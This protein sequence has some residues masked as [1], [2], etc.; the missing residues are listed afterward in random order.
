M[1]QPELAIWVC[2]ADYEPLFRPMKTV[3]LYARVSTLDQSCAMQLEDLRRYASQRFDRQYEYVDTGV[4]GTQRSRPQLDAL[5]KDAH[6]R[7]FGVVLVWKFDRFAR[8]LKHLIDSLAEFGA[9]GIN[10]ISFTE[11]IDTTTPSGQLLFHIVGAVAQFERDLISERVRAGIAHARAIGKHIGRPRAQV[12][13]EQVKALRG[14]GMS[15]RSIARAVG[16]PVSRVRR[17]LTE[18]QVNK[19]GWDSQ[20][21][22]QAPQERS[23]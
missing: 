14:Q 15:L 1:H 7:L 16:I 20:A 6:K 9:L 13:I 17:A 21:K 10:F 4:S 3:A 8:S 11:G 2:F 18:R 5:M 22:G 12:D 23:P 19:P